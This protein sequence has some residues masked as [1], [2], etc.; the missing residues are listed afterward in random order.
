MI[1]LGLGLDVRLVGPVG[2]D[3]DLLD[4]TLDLDLT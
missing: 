4:M 3:L 1:C 2:L